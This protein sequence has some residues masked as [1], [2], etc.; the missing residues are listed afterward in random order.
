VRPVSDFA[1]EGAARGRSLPAA[2]A[3]WLEKE[4]CQELAAEEEELVA[5]LAGEIRL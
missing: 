1:G 5:L 3:Q 2:G 4:L